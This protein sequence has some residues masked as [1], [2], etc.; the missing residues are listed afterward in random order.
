MLSCLRVRNFAI[1]AE[2]EVEL[3][4]GLNVVTGETGAGKSILVDALQLVLG[5]K[6]RPDLVRTGAKS[7]EVEALFTLDGQ[8]EARARLAAMGLEL[9]DTDDAELVVRRVVQ[10]NG[11]TRAFVNG[12][13]VTASQLNQVVA[14]LADICS[15]HEYHTL[16]EPHRHLAYLDAF[17]QLMSQR[18]EVGQTH[19]ALASISAELDDLLER[20]K[21]RGEREDLLRFQLR[22]IDEVNPSPGENEE[23]AQDR[24]RLKHA[25]RLASGTGEAEQAL[26]AADD[27][28]C[29]ALSRIAMNVEELARIDG[30]LMPIADQLKAAHAQLEDAARELGG[31]ARELNVDPSELERVEERLHEIKRLMRKHGGTIDAM[32]LFRE[33]ADRELRELEDHEHA[34][35]TLESRRGVAL[36]EARKAA[37]KL[38]R[39]RKMAA[40]RLGKA[41]SDE[42]RSLGMGDATVMVDVAPTQGG[43][44][45]L[46]VDGAKLTP[47]GID[48]AEFLIA[49]NRGEEARPLRKVA[50][51]GELSRA[52]LAIKRVL[53]GLGS[54]GLYVFDEVDSGVGG[55]VAEAIGLKLRDVAQHHQVL[56]ITHLPQIAVFG[57]AHFHVRKEVVDERTQSAIHRLDNKARLQEVARMLGGIKVT[58]KT[59]DAAAEMLDQAQRAC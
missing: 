55:A 35:A 13:L 53:A 51:G 2:L 29:D 9:P 54:A 22:E 46:V 32:L 57:D 36:D 10:P 45:E 26:Y 8:P 21:Q 14:G 44:G 4:P 34:V 18:G 49:P 24:E 33:E 15:Q 50:S 11:R 23:L 39:A 42:L 17:G 38:S 28:I 5:G 25:G 12:R 20:I 1:I 47:S 58:S 56:C 37:Q 43:E 41:I 3:E 59:R 7:A 27:A 52:M 19:S 40:S 31:Y 6:G 16:V 30:T 48:R